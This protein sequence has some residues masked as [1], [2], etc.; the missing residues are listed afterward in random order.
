[1]EFGFG[2]IDMEEIRKN[3]IIQCLN[4]YREQYGIIHTNVFITGKTNSGK[5]T[6]ENLLLGKKFFEELDKNDTTSKVQHIQFFEKLNFYDLPGTESR[7]DL[8]NMN[9]AC[10]RLEQLDVENAEVRQIPIVS[11]IFDG[12]LK[13]EERTVSVADFQESPQ[14]EPHLIFYLLSNASGFSEEDDYVTGMLQKWDVIFIINQ[15]ES[16]ENVK[17]NADIEKRLFLLHARSGA[18]KRLTMLKVNCRAGAGLEQVFDAACTILGQE[19]GRIFG[20]IFWYQFKNTPLIF[21]ETI[22]R[23]LRAGYEFLSRQRPELANGQ[24]F[25]IDAFSHALFQFISHFQQLGD[26]LFNASAPA[27]PAAAARRLAEQIK[28]R[29]AKKKIVM[30]KR[31]GKRKTETGELDVLDDVEEE[32]TTFGPY[33]LHAK[34]FVMFHL[35]IHE[36]S[37]HFTPGLQ[38]AD[39]LAQAVYRRKIAAKSARPAVFL[40]FMERAVIQLLSVGRTELQD[41]DKHLGYFIGKFISSPFIFHFR[42][43]SGFLINSMPADLSWKTENA[44]LCRLETGEGAVL[45]VALNNEHHPFSATENVSLRLIAENEEGQAAETLAVK[46]FATPEVK[47]LDMQPLYF[48]I[49]AAAVQNPSF[50]HGAMIFSPVSLRLPVRLDLARVERR[51]VTVSNEL[52]PFW[53]QGLRYEF[54]AYRKGL[55]SALSGFDELLKRIFNSYKTKSD[56]HR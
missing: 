27:Y 26:P 29:C 39:A 46:I 23:E 11:A 48:S 10:L 4:S 16:F 8:E 38:E 12:T 15:I 50:N 37:R 40:Y 41:G 19:R 44:T 54:K 17:S 28:G 21:R 53:Q 30:V 56:G 20:S 6:F 22:N 14:F 32:E 24:A 18:A 51:K 43:T 36:C 42:T 55:W 47:M 5:T 33:G 34:V 35:V 13:A 49:N 3:C 2:A 31:P 25:D 9:R 45:K 52:Y 1:M 7:Y